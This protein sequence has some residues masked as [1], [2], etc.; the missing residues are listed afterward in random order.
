MSER[1]GLLARLLNLPAMPEEAGPGGPP[2]DAI[3]RENASVPKAQTA[4]AEGPWIPPAPMTA[5]RLV[6]AVDATA[7]RVRTWA[8]AKEL[9]DNLFGAL[10]GNLE[11][12][13]AVHAGNKVKLF[14]R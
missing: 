12:A 5:L 10:P 4:E 11:V 13:F 7:S 6:L 3:V 8:A 9:T 14:T 1:K 2:A